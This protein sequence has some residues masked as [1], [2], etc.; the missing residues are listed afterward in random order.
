VGQDY[1]AR[2]EAGYRFAVPVHRGLVGITPY[3]AVQVQDFHTPTYSETD[4][5]GGGFGLSYAAMSGTD[6]RSELGARF[7]DP[8]LL[9]SLPLILRARLAWAH[10]WVSNPALNAA[11][12]ALPGTGFTVNR[13]PIPKDS[14]LTSAGAQLFFT[15]NW[16]LIAK[17]DG[18]FA[19]GSQTYDGIGQIKY[20]W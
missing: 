3:A 15:P 17:F 16:S 9:G 11:F 10:D 5:T 13:A 8:T 20:S 2:L 14:T 4:L 7:D 12:Q 1:G 19:S 6:T 18:E